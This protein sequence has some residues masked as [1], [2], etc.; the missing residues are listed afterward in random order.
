MN[1][2][3]TI[4]LEG[5]QFYTRND[6]EDEYHFVLVCPLYDSLRKNKFQNI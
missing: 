2:P 5:I 4:L 1:K 3:N 6:L